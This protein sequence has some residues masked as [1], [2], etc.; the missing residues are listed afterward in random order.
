MIY[1]FSFLFYLITWSLDSRPRDEFLSTFVVEDFE[2]TIWTEKN[3]IYRGNPDHFPEI[4]TSKSLT[5]PNLISETSLLLRFPKGTTEQNIEIRF[6]EPKP[7]TDFVISF[8]FHLYGNSQGGSL[9]ILIE[10]SRLEHHILPIGNLNFNG[11]K[12]FSVKL[13]PSIQQGNKFLKT[14]SS[15]RILG[16]IYNSDISNSKNR[17][18]LLAIDDIIALTIQKIKIPQ[19]MEKS[20]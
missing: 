10:D 19:E 15:I 9:S 7:V 2:S 12:E 5:S 4:R 17:E 11:W 16:L 8:Q 1:L 14:P 6:P 13:N 18:D 20:F 3:V